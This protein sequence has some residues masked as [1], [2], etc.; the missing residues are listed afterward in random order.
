MLK[1]RKMPQSIDCSPIGTCMQ[2]QRQYNLARVRTA[3]ENTAAC[4][5]MCYGVNC[6]FR[7]RA[8]CSKHFGA[9]T[10]FRQ[11]VQDHKRRA[12]CCM[13]SA[14]A[15]RVGTGIAVHSAMCGQMQEPFMVSAGLHDH[16]REAA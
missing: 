2:S 7:L 4:L 6:L 9:R 16:P 15:C 14:E 12:C 8:H 10:T 3:H 5:V 13:G 1:A 11:S